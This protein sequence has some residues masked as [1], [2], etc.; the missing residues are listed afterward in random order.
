MADS[1][2][3]AFIGGGNMAFSRVR[4]SADNAQAADGA[5]VVVL[6]VKPQMMHEVASALGPA[7]GDPAPLVLSIAAGVRSGDILRWLGRDFALVRCMPNTPAL[8]QCGASG[9]YAS[10]RV[11]DAQRN[12]AETVMRSA[13]LTLWVDAEPLLDA[14]TALSGS[15]PAYVFLLMEAMSEAGESLGLSA[16]QA[17][18]LT[19]ET[20]FGA[21]KMA[22]EA[23]E[24]PADLRLGVT[25]PGGTTE[26]AI[27]HFES[28]GFRPLVK[29]AVEAACQR[30][31]EL[32]DL[33][34]KD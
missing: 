8:V 6:A 7:L 11:S 3:I 2:I 29:E 13:G 23:R 16:E 9:L 12:L 32:G 14:V 5:D 28:G 19:L 21:S 15:G 18:L 4:T 22:L 27:D 25:S 26:R 33:L 1:P 20:V 34:G 31:R 30:A 10:E 17:R 24:S